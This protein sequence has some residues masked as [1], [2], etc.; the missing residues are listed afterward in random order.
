M[1]KYLPESLRSLIILLLQAFLILPSTAVHA[2]DNREIKG[3][4]INVTDKQPI[5]G[6]SIYHK[7]KTIGTISD[8][9]GNYSLAVSDTTTLVFSSIGFIRK[10]IK[11]G[12]LLVINVS[13]EEDVVGLDEVVII[14][15]GEQKRSNLSGAVAS[16]DVKSLANRA[17]TRLDQALQG[18]VSGVTV[19]RNGGA[20]GA[21]PTVHIRGVGS[22]GDTEPLWIVD[23]IRMSPG[24]HFEPD[25]VESIEVLKDAS[26]SAIY[27]ASAA[28]GVILVTTKRGKGAVQINLNSSVGR[29][30]PV[31]LPTL[32]NSADF[33][34]YKKQSREAAGQNPEPSWDSYEHDTDWV[35]AFYAGSGVIQ[36]HDLS[37]SKGDDKYNYFFS[38]GNDAED[39]IL[40]DNSFHRSSMR[41]N[42]DVRINNWL[43][44]GESILVSKVVENPIGNNDENFNGGIP[45][46]SIPIM[47]IRDAENLYGGWGMGPVYFQGP[48][49]VATQYQQHDTRTYRRLDGNIYGEITPLKG[50]SIRATLGYNYLGF[51]QERFEEAFDYGSFEETKAILTYATAHDETIL[52]NGVATYSKNI[53]DHNFKAMAGY[54]GIQFESK[55]FGLAAKEFPIDVA[56]SINLAK[57][58]ISAPDRFN[59]YQSRLL[60]QFGR[61]NYNYKEKYLLEVNIRRDASAPKFGPSNLWGIFPSYSIGWKIS[62][63]KFFDNVP[64]ISALKLRASSGKLGS[65]NIQN[66]LYLKTYTSQFSFYSFD[67]EGA[68]KVPGFFVSKFPN[69]DVKWEEVNMHNIAM[70]IEAFEGKVSLSLDYYIKDTKDLLYG[71]PIPLSVGIAVHNF[72][73]V[74]PEIN[75]GSMRNR[76]VDIDMGYK[77]EFGKFH[78]SINANASFLKNELRTLK[79]DASITGGAAGRHMGGMT[80]T[81]PGMPLSSFYG[82]IV[83]KMFQSD[84]E[85]AIMNSYAND[86]YYQ[87]A[88]TTGGDLMYLDISGPDGVPDNEITAEYDRTF[89]GNPWPKMLYGLNVS[90]TWNGLVDFALQFQG[91]QGVDIF[92]A[93]KAYS[94]N[95]FGDNNTTTDIFQAWTPENHS[96][97]PRNIASDPN[98]NFSRP[99]TYFVED[100]SYLKLRN[101]Q[102]GLTL[103]NYILQKIRIKKLRLYLNANN[104][105][106]FTKYSGLDP[107][108]AG[109]NTSRGVDYGVYPQVRSYTA[110]LQLQF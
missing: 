9:E 79:G 15:Y 3:N 95:F 98:Q 17:Q 94:R 105:L 37:I 34:R 91:V 102:L 68:N 12:N 2:Q 76:G 80:R 71:V 75:I 13:L 90:A 29:R 7:G 27:G 92:N 30:S 58:A 32:L 39:G 6:V 57:G 104:V 81:E 109:S 24:N 47:P 53:G 33:V 11:V 46:R 65:D 5:P 18:M 107:E 40:I 42:S 23:G 60:S 87:E 96:Q 22:M 106:T 54:E 108:V 26:A 100:G 70:D 88:A 52:G 85:V 51:L 103:P 56:W 36:S 61:F 83:Y 110:G 4:V 63:E 55:H 49:P 72:D 84:S 1:K 43:K 66:F 35:D 97:H 62:E 25:D 67:E 48:N 78:I 82:Y 50:L 16:V 74:N 73:P 44:I 77:N 21:K 89:I 64:V 38:V 10:E 93:S 45:Y 20:P 14:G 59:V 41:L 86:G 101:I 19:T 8:V 69:E 99:S 31:N 28:H